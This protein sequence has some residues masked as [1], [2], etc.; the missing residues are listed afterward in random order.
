MR[1]AL[2]VLAA[3]S[4]V[5]AVGLAVFGI[6]A[7]TAALA[8]SWLCGLAWMVLSAR[9]TSTKLSQVLEHQR[10]NRRGLRQMET[11]L[12]EQS[13]LE[14]QTA[15]QLSGVRRD[16]FRVLIWVQRTPSVTQELRRVYDR[17]VDHD[18]TMPEL[19][20]WAISPSTLVWVLDRLSDSSVRTILEL[21]SGS[22]TI[23]FATALDKRGGEGRVV[24]LESSTDY[25]ERTRTE[26]AKHR[27]QDR[28]QV[29]HAPLVDTAVPGRE[30]QPWFDISV[31]PDLPPIDLLFVDGP[32]GS[33]AHQARYPAYPLLADRLD[34]PPGHRPR[35]TE[36]SVHRAK[37]RL[38]RA[39]A[40]RTPLVQQDHAPL[41]KLQDP[42]ARQR[43]RTL[44][45]Q[46]LP[47]DP[48][49][50]RRHAQHTQ[51]KINI[52]PQHCQRLSDPQT[53]R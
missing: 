26:L 32:V 9:A 44:P 43:L 6:E 17:L 12:S 36:C 37:D 27:L 7:A 29:L 8:V 16:L 40:D 21:G 20:D 4:A 28:A 24:A 5:V 38:I 46:A 53:R 19:G 2:I 23:W 11:R 10:V 48:D 35:I 51:V 33:I 50:G 42:L 13:K 18:R 22:S 34:Q 45:H 52:A 15:S 25:A 31:L 49:Q 3:V 41:R 47:R 14:R 39:Y 30:S 1:R